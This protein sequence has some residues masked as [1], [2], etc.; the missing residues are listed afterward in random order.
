MAV[1]DTGA[2]VSCVSEQLFADLLKEFKHLPVLPVPQTCIVGATGKKSSMI[3][4]QVLLNLRKGGFTTDWDFLVVKSLLKPIIIG[5]DFVTRHVTTVDFEKH[6]VG[7]KDK[8]GSLFT[9]DLALGSSLEGKSNVNLYIPGERDGAEVLSVGEKQIKEDGAHPSREEFLEVVR[10]L[11]NLTGKQKEELLTVLVQ[12]RTT[13]SEV[14]GRHHTYFARIRLTGEQPFFQRSYP[15]PLAYQ[16][17]VEE[18]IQQMLRWDVIERCASPY[19]SPLCCV[20][21]KDS[22]VRLC[23]DARKLNLRIEKDRDSPTPPEEILKWCEEVRF[24][25]STDLTHG[26]WQLSLHPED[27]KYVSFLYKART[28]CFKVLPFGIANAVAE[29]TRCMDGVLGPECQPFARAYLDDIIIHSRTFDDHL[30]H[31]RSVFT[32]IRNVGM[33]LKLKKSLFCREEMPFLGFIVTPRGVCSDPEKLKVIQDFP[34]P[35]NDRQLKG[36]L[37]ILGFYRKFT[38]ELAEVTAPLFELLKKGVKW[39]WTEKTEEAFRQAKTLFITSCTLYHPV[40]GVEFVLTTDASGYAIGAKLAQNVDGEERI[41]AMNSRLLNSAERHYTVTERECLGFVWALQRFRSIVLGSPLQIQTDHKA[42]TFML[43]C[44]IHSSRIRRWI[45]AIQEFDYS[46]V[47]VKGKENMQVDALSRNV[48]GLGGELIDEDKNVTPDFCVL[49]IQ[50]GEDTTIQKDFKRLP[51]LQREDLDLRKIRNDLEKEETEETPALVRTRLLYRVQDDILLRLVNGVD[52]FLQH[53]KVCVPGMI[54]E[55]LM[56]YIHHLSGHFGARKCFWQARRFFYWKNMEKHF[57][58]VIST[59]ELCQKVKFPNMSYAGVLQPI[60]PEE[61]NILVSVDIFGP[62]PVGQGGLKYLL[63]FLDCFSK[64]CRIY[65]LKTATSA[66]CLRRVSQYVKEMG[67]PKSILTDH[68]TQFVSHQWY[69][70]LKKLNIIPTHTS[71]RHPASNPVERSNREIGRILRTYCHN[72]QTTWPAYVPFMNVLFNNLIQESTGITPVSLHFG[73]PANYNWIRRLGKVQEEQLPGHH[74]LIE[75]ARKRMFTL[76][77]RRGKNRKSHPAF[78]V[79]ELVLLKERPTS[80][81][82]SKETKKLFLVFSGPYS[83]QRVIKN[84]AY[85]LWCNKR[86]SIRGVFNADSLKPFKVLNPNSG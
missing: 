9:L 84:N 20:V 41:I 52:P 14:P 18:Q 82:F 13:F 86:N 30:Q 31:I 11:D 43:S 63:V 44:R 22:S 42:L 33:T 1:I 32:K 48:P 85:E 54:Q 15:I 65:P 70:G 16:S 40:A 59:C 35:R 12:N 49:N 55:K 23:L 68:G 29:F 26:Y 66:S 80:N 2:S 24:L 34:S 76:A 28:Y 77:K 78:R 74:V 57:K 75:T 67:T 7:M 72:K 6:A 25:S 83:I 19:A 58:K 60:L 79:G 3:N 8:N 64:F 47:Y 39:N 27:R 71:I 50:L 62:L 46:I 4:K 81:F 73:R 69:E 53:W 45:L 36:F 5:M 38:T 10:A 17:K 37:G 61:P 21:K 51:Q 56:W